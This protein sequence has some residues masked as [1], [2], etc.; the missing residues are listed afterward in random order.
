MKS[1]SKT[2]IDLSTL[3]VEIKNAQGEII[4]D[5]IFPEQRPVVRGDANLF[6]NIRRVIPKIQVP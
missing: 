3:T 1:K 4:G 5:I 2:D 6:R